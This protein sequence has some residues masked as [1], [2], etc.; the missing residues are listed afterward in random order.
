MKRGSIRSCGCY[1]SRMTSE[2]KRI[3]GHTSDVKEGKRYSRFYR[4]WGSMKNRC[5]TD[6]KVIRRYYKDR[7]ITYDTN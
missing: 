5:K 2:R 7:G 1:K 3:H 6:N 4:I